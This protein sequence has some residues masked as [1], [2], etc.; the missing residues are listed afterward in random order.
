MI[1]RCC[2]GASDP[3]YPFVAKMTFPARTLP[4][5][6]VTVKPARSRTNSVTRQLPFTSAPADC[7][8]ASNPRWY[9]P[10][11]MLATWGSTAP[12]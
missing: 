3:L 6:V 2:Q 8:A 9:L 4:L 7:A 1:R 11:S 10:G 5:P 12:P